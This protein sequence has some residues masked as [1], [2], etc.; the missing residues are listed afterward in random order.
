M[1][2]IIE[3]KTKSELKAFIDFQFRLYEK[4]PFWVPPIKNEELPSKVHQP[5]NGDLVI[6]PSSLFHE[7]IP[8]K[9]ELER[10]VIAFDLKNLSSGKHINL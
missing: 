6:F 1:I 4:C 9:Q 8:V 5:V 7:T 10:C 2:E 3:V